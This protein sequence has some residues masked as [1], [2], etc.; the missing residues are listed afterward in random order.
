MAWFKSNLNE[1]RAGRTTKIEFKGR[2]MFGYIENGQIATVVPFASQSL[3]PGDL[4]FGRFQGNYLIRLI[5][6]MNDD[7]FEIID[8][9]DKS[10]G[11]VSSDDIHGKVITISTPND[12]L[13]TLTIEGIETSPFNIWIHH[14]SFPYNCELQMISSGEVAQ[15][16]SASLKLF[17]SDR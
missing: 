7:R 17:N 1:L 4:V 15:T 14:Q 9:H 5:N 6:D 8:A 12:L 16:S 2:T 3:K 13:A 11:W 10:F